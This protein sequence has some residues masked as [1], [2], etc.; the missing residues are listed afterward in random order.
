MSVP[1]Y[2]AVSFNYLETLAVTDVANTITR[3][4]TQL[5]A[6]SW[7]SLGGGQYQSPTDSGGRYLKL[8]FTKISATQ[9]EMVLLD[10]LSR[11]FTRRAAVLQQL[12][13]GLRSGQRAGHL[14]EHVR[15]VPGASGLPRPVR[16]GPRLP[17]RRWR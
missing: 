3:I 1:N 17:H 10:S 12:R 6:L 11:T 16:H 2:L 4:G 14:G 13:H 15:H 8:T 5:V 7:T 9:I